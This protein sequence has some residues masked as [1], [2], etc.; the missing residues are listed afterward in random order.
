MNKRVLGSFSKTEVLD[1]E[2][3]LQHMLKI[4]ASFGEKKNGIQTQDL[5]TSQTPLATTEPTTGLST[6]ESKQVCI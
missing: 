5:N 3:V 4:D 1:V 2:P 6:E